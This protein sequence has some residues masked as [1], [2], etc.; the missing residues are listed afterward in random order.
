M[1]V[2]TEHRISEYNKQRKVLMKILRTHTHHITV[3]ALTEALQACLPFTDSN[4]SYSETENKLRIGLKDIYDAGQALE[5]ELLNTT[6]KPH[7]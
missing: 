1:P 4:P 3:G 5:K 2:T 6:D 7:G